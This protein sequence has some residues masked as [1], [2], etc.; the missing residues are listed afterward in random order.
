MDS[1]HLKEL[2]NLPVDPQMKGRVLQRIKQ[3]RKKRLSPSKPFLVMVGMVFIALFLLLVPQQ[4]ELVTSSGVE[5][6]H[7]Y[8]YFGGEEGKFFARSST[9]YSK[10]VEKTD[11]LLFDFFDELPLHMVESNG[12]LGNHIVD[13]IVVRDNV[14]ERYQVS[15][16]DMLNVDTGQFYTANSDKYGQVFNVLYDVE[17]GVGILPFLIGTLLINAYSAWYYK[18]HKL[19][20]IKFGGAWDYI[21]MM[22]IFGSIAGLV[23]WMLTI[24]PLY[25]PF[26]VL[27]AAVYGWVMWQHIK[28][29]VISYR[30]FKFEMTRIICVTLL[31]MGLVWTY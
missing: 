26:L 22:I 16:E 29:K 27:L 13:V 10:V 30:S 23:I 1:N 7:I 4:R 18:R 15:D 3:P 21:L 17:V 8:S 31:L 11:P 25:K 12:K 28:R 24:G 19:E 6:E 5:I 20:K 9:L 2:N 14:N